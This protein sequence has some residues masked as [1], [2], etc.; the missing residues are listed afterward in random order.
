MIARRLLLA[1]PVALLAGRAFAQSAVAPASAASVPKAPPLPVKFEPARDPKADLA[2]ALAMAKA[3]RKHV[4]VDVGG[5]WCPWCHILDRF[6][7]KHA[8]VKKLVDD[9][10]VW[11]KVNYSKQNENVAVLSR[12]PKV[13]GYPHLFVLDSSGGIVLSQDTGLL[14]SGRTYD[15]RRFLDFLARATA[16]QP[17]R[18]AS[19][20]GPFGLV[21][22]PMRVL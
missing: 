11:L 15:K 6:V 9:H 20:Y 4:M 19:G 2:T 8:D 22:P 16:T 13:P 17:S 21:G 18:A 5:E 12:W 3:Q 14:E 10:Y 7:A 1:G